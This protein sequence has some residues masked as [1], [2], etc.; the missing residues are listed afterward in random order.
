MDAANPPK[1]RGPY[2]QNG[3][4]KIFGGEMT[5]AQVDAGIAVMRG[6][7]DGTRVMKAL[8]DAGVRNCVSAAEVL[9]N[10]ELKAGHIRRITR[11]LYR[12]NTDRDSN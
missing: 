5:Q 9:I 10:R 7:F 11:G 12:V 3:V 6:E 8:S 2:K 1:K 4:M